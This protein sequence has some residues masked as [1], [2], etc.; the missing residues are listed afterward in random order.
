MLVRLL[1]A[2]RT[3]DPIKPEQA[4]DIVRDSRDHNPAHGITG[5]LCYSERLFIQVLEGGREEV[6]ALYARIVSDPRHY[7]VMLLD[8]AEITERRFTEWSMGRVNLE[9]QNPSLLLKYSPTA[10]LDPYGLSGK[11]SLALLEEM[12]QT[13]A[14]V[15]GR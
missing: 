1:Y 11:V 2:S 3:R 4:D 7:D 5:I 15:P 9:K 14:V 6:N 13:A 8:Y 10:R 12:I